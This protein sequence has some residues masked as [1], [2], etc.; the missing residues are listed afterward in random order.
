MVQEIIQFNG[1]WEIAHGKEKNLLIEEL[2]S[3]TVCLEQ[4]PTN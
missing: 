4:P 3:K 1:S 2:A